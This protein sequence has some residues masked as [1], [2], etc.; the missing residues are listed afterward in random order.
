MAKPSAS[1]Q[2]IRIKR[3][4]EALQV[5]NGH[6]N[7][8]NYAIRLVDIRCVIRIFIVMVQFSIGRECSERKKFVRNLRP[9]INELKQWPDA[10]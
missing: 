2:N 3:I 5:E 4:I 6:M 1:T 7:D 8:N 9:T 10:L